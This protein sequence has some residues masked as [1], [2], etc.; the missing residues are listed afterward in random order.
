LLLASDQQFPVNAHHNFCRLKV[1][2]S[3]FLVTPLLKRARDL[4]TKFAASIN[5]K[6][7]ITEGKE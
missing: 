1:L 5:H 3:Q 6:T 2:D 7:T 4:I